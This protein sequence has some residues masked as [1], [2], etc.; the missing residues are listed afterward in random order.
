MSKI[1]QESRAFRHGSSSHTTARHHDRLRR[2]WVLPSGQ[3]FER[4]R[5][6]QSAS[7]KRCQGTEEIQLL[8]GVDP[9]LGSALQSKTQYLLMKQQTLRIFESKKYTRR[10]LGFADPYVHLDFHFWQT[11]DSCLFATKWQVSVFERLMPSDA[12]EPLLFAGS[13]S[14]WGGTSRSLKR[15]RIVLL[16]AESYSK[17]MVS[18][19]CFG[20]LFLLGFVPLGL[21]QAW[22]VLNSDG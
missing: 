19:N 10:D 17:V 7:T 3:C 13:A 22:M 2:R 21:V 11:L 5:I 16:R 8:N 1:T 4:L 15:R 12:Q 9:S 20:A 18:T 14:F 6:V